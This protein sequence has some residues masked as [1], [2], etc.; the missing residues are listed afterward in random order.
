MDLS[1]LPP[2]ASESS[3]QGTGVRFTVRSANCPSYSLA[4]RSGFRKTRRFSVDGKEDTEGIRESERRGANAGANVTNKD[5]GRTTG[6]QARTGCPS[7]VKG[8]YEEK[9]RSGHDMSPKL[10]HRGTGD[11]LISGTGRN[12][13]PAFESE[14][15][16]KSRDCNWMNRRKS[17]DWKTEAR[18]CSVETRAEKRG[19]DF[20]NH[21]GGLDER[22]TGAD[23]VRG[24]VMSSIHAYNSASTSN[25]VTEM[26]PVSHMS[27][28]WSKTNRGCSLPSR[29][30]SYT[31]PGAEIAPSE[32]VGGQSIME[33]IEKLYGSAG[34]GKAE[35]GSKIRNPSSRTSLTWTSQRLNPGSDTSHSPGRRRR[36]SGEQWQGKIQGRD[37]VEGQGFTGEGTRSLDRARSRNTVA[38]QMR[39]ARAA[40]QISSLPLAKNSHQYETSVS[41]KNLSEFTERKAHENT[42][43]G[44]AKHRE[45]KI[46]ANGI[47]KAKERDD[48]AKEKAQIRYSCADEDVFVSNLEKNTLK[49]PERKKLSQMLSVPSAASVRNKISQF[50][51]LS[52][53]AHGLATGQILMPRRAFSV[54]TQLN[55]SHEGVKQGG[56]AKA[57]GGLKS[58][59]EGIKDGGEVGDKSEE[60]VTTAGK[61][62]VSERSFS[63]DEV[64]LRLKRKAEGNDLTENGGK[65]KNKGNNS[66]GTLEV[67]QKEGKGGAQ[68]RHPNFYVDET[69]FPK[70][71]S[72]DEP[73][74]ANNTPSLPL[75]DPSETAATVQK[76]ASSEIPSPVSDDDKTPTNT[77]DPSPFHSPTAQM[78]K[79]SAFVDKYDS[80][81]AFPQVGKTPDPGPQP[82]PQPLHTS[83]PSSFSSP[84]SPDVKTDYQKGKSQALDL[85]AWVACL[86]PGF[87]VWNDDDEDDNE[88]DDES[89]QK[90]EDSNYD[91]DS[92][93]SSVT[94]TSN[95]SQSDRRSFSVSL[96]DLCDFAGVDYESESDNE[97]PSTG[98]RSASL[99]SDVS[100][101]SYVSVMPTEELDK[102]ME[103]VRNL[104]DNVLQEYNDV[105]VVVLHK[106][107]G[108][109][110]GFSVAGGVDENK[111]VTVHKV[112]HSGV[113][114]QEGSVREG[115]Q[116]LSIN[117]TALQNYTHWEALRVLRRAKIRET[118]VVVLR[119]GGVNRVSKGGVQTNNQGATQP[120]LIETGQRVCVSLEKNNRDLGFSLEGGVGSSMGNRPLTVQKIFQGGPVDKVHPGDE[121]LEIGGVSMVGK[122]RLEAWTLIRN[123]STGPVDVVLHRP[124][125]H[126]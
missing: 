86:N 107:V 13:N 26:S 32:S 5:E 1:L 17:L 92:G 9:E 24:R 63:V 106:E 6:Y 124:L 80:A 25:D 116:V 120:P 41:L 50:E 66:A 104:G 65:E 58:K 16:T 30:R 15:G 79:C 91:S 43:K 36:L 81:H 54:P 56:S 89:T 53:R 27:R 97:W 98:R 102:L 29:F 71:S 72:P 84:I 93:E 119:K 64:K 22:G 7:S 112:F 82:V 61:K 100:A 88:D 2:P 42:D 126:T 4:F 21:T 109:G 52:Q 8:L 113:A 115:D 83:S 3:K 49:T 90:D 57:I 125:K 37:S 118:G 110:L 12:E 59:W 85:D 33:R 75:F 67:Q 45:D 103:D 105:Q 77:P 96:A 78:E 94:I 70:L 87:K 74:K 40:G 76:M 20:D 44:R 99:S 62:I 46:E 121:V 95:M 47:N 68:T 48:G 108:V 28:T 10:D 69:D 35:D 14:C 122:R 117:G 11:K 39:S 114:A 18:T 73:K 51:A 34:L 55:S 19:R 111:P 123:L 23:Y 31:G 101:L 60:K 38:A